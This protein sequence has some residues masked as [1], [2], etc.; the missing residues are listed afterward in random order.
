MNHRDKKIIIV[1]SMIRT[2]KSN[3]KWGGGVCVENEWA[4]AAYSAVGLIARRQKLLDVNFVTW[5]HF[6]SKNSNPPKVIWLM[7]ER[8]LPTRSHGLT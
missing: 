3:N 7:S 5:L 1:V 8:V 4:G 6:L 2:R